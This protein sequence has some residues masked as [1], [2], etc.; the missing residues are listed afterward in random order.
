MIS[1]LIYHNRVGLNL[2]QDEGDV[3]LILSRLGIILWVL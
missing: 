2:T 3:I 1:K